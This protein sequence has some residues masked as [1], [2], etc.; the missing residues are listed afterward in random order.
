MNTRVCVSL[1]FILLKLPNFSD[2]RLRG[3]LILISIFY[4]LEQNARH[5]TKYRSWRTQDTVLINI[6]ITEKTMSLSKS[7]MSRLQHGREKVE[8]QEIGRYSPPSGHRCFVK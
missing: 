6:C 5:Q 4:S 8:M 7:I 3:Y 2:I 1:L